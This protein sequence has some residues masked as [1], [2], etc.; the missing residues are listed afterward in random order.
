MTHDDASAAVAN[1]LIH[2]LLCKKVDA[3]C[4][5]SSWQRADS[6]FLSEIERVKW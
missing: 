4:Q 1:G 5:H 3:G 6:I 2:K